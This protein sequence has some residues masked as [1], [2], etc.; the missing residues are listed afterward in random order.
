[1]LV[2]CGAD[3]GGRRNKLHHVT[4][5]TKVAGDLG[6]EEDWLRNIALEMEIGA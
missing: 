2:F 4:T 3:R 6:E 5:I 1:M